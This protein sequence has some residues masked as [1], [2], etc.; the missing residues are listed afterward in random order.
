[1]EVGIG[2]STSRPV[3]PSSIGNA[4]GVEETAVTYGGIRVNRKMYSV[5]GIRAIKI[6]VVNDNEDAF[7]EAEVEDDDSDISCFLLSLLCYTHLVNG[8]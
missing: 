5:N 1:M 6:R 4:T 3:S 2:I 8:R 7:V